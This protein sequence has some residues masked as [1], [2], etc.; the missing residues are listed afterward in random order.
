MTPSIHNLIK[1]L[2]EIAVQQYL[3]E[4]RQQRILTT[5]A[6]EE[7]L[8]K[9]W[10]CGQDNAKSCPKESFINQKRKRKNKNEI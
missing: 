10:P 8:A 5:Q 2:A 3:D 7:Q 4:Q 9:P 1:F 6:T